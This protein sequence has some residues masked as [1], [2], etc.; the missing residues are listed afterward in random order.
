MTKHK[1]R[2]ILRAILILTIIC[3]IYFISYF[4][5]FKLADNMVTDI[6]Y[7]RPSQINNQIKIIAIDEKTLSEYGN[8]TS[9][10]RQKYA[11]LLNTINESDEVKPNIIAF[12]IIYSADSDKEGDLNFAEECEKGD[13]VIVASNII[14]KE[15]LK[16]DENDKMYKDLLNIKSVEYPFSE[17]NSVAKSGFTNALQD[18][19]NYIRHSFVSLDYDSSTMYSFPFLIYKTH[20]ES[21]NK[22]VNY[23]KTDEF[24][25]FGFSYSATPQ[26]RYEVFSLVDV[27][28]GKYSPSTFDDCIVLVGAYASGMQDAYLVPIAQNSQMFGV[29][30]HANIVDS[31]LKETTTTPVDLKVVAIIY[32]I[33]A[34][35]YFIIISKI[36]IVPTLILLISSIVLHIIL[37]VLLF[38][39]GLFVGVITLPII[40]TVLFLYNLISKYIIETIQKKKII[41][42]F[43]RYIEPQVVEDLVSSGN[44]EI[45]LNGELRDIAAVFVDIRNFTAIS[46][47]LL[48]EEVVKL[49]NEYLCL[50]TDSIFKNKGT[51]DK[52]IGDSAMA[53]FN[54]PFDLEDYEYKA[55]CTAC[56]IIENSKKLEEKLNKDYGVSVKCGIGIHC[57]NAVI[58]NIGSDTRIDYTAI[59]DTVNIASRLESHATEDQILISDTVYEKVKDKVDVT[60]L[61]LVK[62]KGKSSEIMIYQVNY[63]L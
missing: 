34:F 54:A 59:G 14:F 35:A 5:A 15:S 29:E 7:Q 48:P 56:D 20:L 53:I 26:S 10:S 43:K 52:F 2:T 3:I 49:L 9:W 51:L 41:N 22:E 61:G 46:E 31:L 11:D 6:L 45:K 28:D 18:D 60:P 36:K 30:I 38:N 39:M 8:I 47:K 37:S 1:I 25:R 21:N 27:L 44:F 58:G 33:I 13:N 55:V 57:G 63:I 19:D 24:N 12:D 23:P 16:Y 42:A 62:L 32:I 40:L 17:L 50:I 4:E